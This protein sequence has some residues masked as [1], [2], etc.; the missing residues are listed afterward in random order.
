MFKWIAMTVL[1]FVVAGALG[2]IFLRFSRRLRDIQR[3]KWGDSA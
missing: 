3:G 2:F 1:S